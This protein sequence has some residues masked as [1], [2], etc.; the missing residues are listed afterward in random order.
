MF[1]NISELI[2]R[3]KCDQKTCSNFDHNCLIMLDQKHFILCANDFCKWDKAIEMGKATLDLPPLNVKDSPVESRK[4]QISI[5]NNN[6]TL[7]NDNFPSSYLFPSPPYS[8]PPSSYPFM[9]GYS[10]SGYPSYGPSSSSV[11]SLAP[12]TLICQ[13]IQSV[14]SS[15]IDSSSVIN[16]L[17]RLPFS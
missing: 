5:I 2:K 3:T 12:A 1:S 17:L 15:S 11:M 6:M 10:I 9:R 4:S 13:D 14:F 7:F 8:F 16:E